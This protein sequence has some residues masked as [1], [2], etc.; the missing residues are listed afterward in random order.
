[1]EHATGDMYSMSV[2]Y[3]IIE[4]ICYLHLT[5]SF[6]TYLLPYFTERPQT[7]IPSAFF[8]LL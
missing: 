7:I 6:V 1:M 5:Q 2:I 8:E 3:S 4:C